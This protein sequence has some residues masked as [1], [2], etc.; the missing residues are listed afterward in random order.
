[1]TSDINKNINDK[2]CI[3]Y[4]LKKIDYCIK[5]NGELV[6]FDPLRSSFADQS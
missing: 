1:M 2:L 4:K 5:S 3:F 6:Y